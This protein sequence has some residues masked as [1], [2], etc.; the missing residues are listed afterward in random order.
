MENK[1]D[2][3]DILGKILSDE[4]DVA[5]FCEMMIQAG[6]EQDEIEKKVQKVRVDIDADL[7]RRL[8]GGN[9][10]IHQVE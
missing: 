1:I 8:M 4:V 2:A 3:I 9:N 10:K 7:K 6:V 5:V